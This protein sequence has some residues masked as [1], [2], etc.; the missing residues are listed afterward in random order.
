MITTR[1]KDGEPITGHMQKMQR[2]KLHSANFK[3]SEDP[4]SGLKVS[5]FT[6]PTPTAAL[7]WQSVKERKEEEEP[8]EGYQGKSLDGS[9]SSGTKKGFVTPSANPK[10]AECYAIEKVALEAK[11]PKVP[12]RCEGWE[13]KTQPCS[14][15]INAF[16]NNVSFFKALP[17][18]GVYETVSVVD[19]L[20][21]NVLCI[22]FSTSLDKTSLWICRLGHVI[23]KR[24]G[25]LQKD[26][27]LESF[28]LKSDDSCESCLLGKMTKSP[29]TGTCAR[30]EGLLDLIH[31]DVCGPFR[32]AT[33]DANRF[34][35][36]FTDDLVDMDM[37]T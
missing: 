25:Q 16:F 6:T 11:L 26:G 7:S 14:G 29:F 5:R 34:Y 36:T 8:F 13:S 18:D 10:E 30:G 4:K 37:S 27:V 9:S 33:R 15:G 2:R 22:D 31:T 1:M 35:V 23:K 19:N 24:I 28:D 21:N 12:A 20:G 3:D 32:T 17:C